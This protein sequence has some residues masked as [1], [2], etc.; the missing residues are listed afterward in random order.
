[1]IKVTQR[2]ATFI[3]DEITPQKSIQSTPTPSFSFSA[4]N[5]GDPSRFLS[6]FFNFFTKTAGNRKSDSSEGNEKQ[7]KLRNTAALPGEIL[8]RQFSL[9][10]IK[11][12]T[13]NFHQNLIIGKGYLGYVYKGFFYDGNLVVAVKR[14]NRGSSDGWHEIQTELQLL[15]Q[16]RHQHL[17]TLIGFYTDNREM[18]LVYEYMRNGTLRDHLNDS[19]NNPLPWKQRLEI[20]IGA[21]RGLH[22]L[23]TGAKQGVI[24]RDV[25][26]A[27]ILLD[28]KWVC[29]LSDFGLSKM[30]S[31]RKS[32]TL[33]KIDSLKGTFGYL[34]PEYARGDGLTEKSDVYSFGVVLFEVLCARKAVDE[35]L[36][37]GLVLLAHWARRSIE[38][39]T[40]CNIIDP[41]LKGRI[42]PE[43]FKL[44]M[45]IAYCCTCEEGNTRPDMG[46]VVVMLELALEL[47]EKA[48]SDSVH[49]A[50]HGEYMYEEVLFS[51]SVPESS[52]TVDSFGVQSDTGILDSSSFI[53]YTGTNNTE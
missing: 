17:I 46:E 36:N 22:Y 4:S 34:A 37:E 44:F 11:A 28:D 7:A 43:C 45:D 13:K 20:C 33:E 21:A 3:L 12:A 1:M 18:I 29:K 5:M 23:H 38:G 16:L 25:K 2:Q 6:S 8:A 40:I 52:S 35:L 27:N 14:S 51:A 47:Q 49:L 50:P 30:R 48:D 19:A 26:S 32:K 9:A 10:E 42:A 41:Y 53:E 39:G 24:H 31:H 15:S